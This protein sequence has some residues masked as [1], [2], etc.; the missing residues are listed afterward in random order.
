M[1]SSAFLFLYGPSGAGKSTL[2]RRLS[3]ALSLPAYDLDA[4]IQQRTG[5][6]PA[7]IF[8]A[9][10]E[11]AFR[12]EERAELR[13]VLNAAPGVVALGGG[14][15]LDESNRALA[16]AHGRVLRLTAGADTLAARLAGSA[17][18]RPLAADPQRLQAMLA[19]RA[20]HYASFPHA[21]DTTAL[22]EDAALDAAQIGLGAWR[23]SAMGSPYSVRVQPGGLDSIGARL[24]ENELNGPLA[25]VSDEHLDDLYAAACWPRWSRPAT[26]PR[27][28]ASPPRRKQDLT[29]LA[30]IWAGW[31][32][33]AWS[34]AAPCWPWAAVSPAT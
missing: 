18:L 15:L 20:A 5:Q 28:S 23:V 4:R 24:R 7:E 27:A 9:R 30:A 32:R 10:G 31:W 19:A 29:T 8:A 26:A 34:A 33:P 2:A 21:L 25:L 16:E 22:S 6:S 1:A 12:A 14:A 17:E 11:A 3:A 13:A